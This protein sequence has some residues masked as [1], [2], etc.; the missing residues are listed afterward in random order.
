MLDAL[1]IY[2]LPL[3]VPISVG[4]PT[5][6]LILGVAFTASLDAFALVSKHGLEQLAVEIS[7]LLI[8]VPLHNLTDEQCLAMG[9]I[10]LRRLV[11]LHLGRTERL[12]T[13]LQ[14]PPST[15]VPTSNCD[16]VDQQRKLGTAWRD[17]IADLAWKA[18]ASTPISLFHAN[19]TPIADKLTCAECKTAVKE[20]I[21]KLIVDWT[22]VKTTI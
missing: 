6:N 8:S 14:E 21:R 20:R 2:G 13:L 16:M 18:N 22:L 5:Y 19:L 9:P 1:P 3:E 12:K 10:Y 17:A 7:H 4:K 11:F 15:H